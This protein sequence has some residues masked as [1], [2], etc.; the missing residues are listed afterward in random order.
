M[1]KIMALAFA[2]VSLAACNDSTTD[3]TT[4]ETTDSTSTTITPAPDTTTT[5][6][7]D[8]N[9][10]MAY[11]PTEGDVTYREKKVRVY[12]SGQWADAD[13]DI[14]LDNGVVVSKNGRVTR[15]GKAI[16]LEDGEVVTKTGNFF[17]RAGNTI[18]KGWDKT[19]EG[20]KDAANA[21]EKGA[22]KVGKEAKDLVTDDDKQKN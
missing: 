3:T 7:T 18:E 11:A 9:T 19:K 2:A 10:S 4:V 21:I 17:D 13:G 15:D 22:K 12:R 14:T 1:K 6:A 8:T 20:V 5:M 16:D